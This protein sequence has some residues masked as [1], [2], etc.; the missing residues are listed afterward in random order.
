MLTLKTDAREISRVGESTAKRLKK[1]GIENA[2]DLLFYFPF[3]YD[4][5]TRLTPIDKLLAGVSANVVGQIELIQN[6]RSWKRR[7]NIT[8]ALITDGTETL[9]VIWFN[10]PFIARNLKVGDKISLAGKVEDDYGSFVMKSPVYEKIQIPLTPFVKGGKYNPPTPPYQGG[11]NAIH[12]QGLVPNYHLT[13]NLTHKQVRFLIKQIITL[14]DGVDDWLPGEIKKDIK[15]INLAEAIRKIHFPKNNSDIKKARERLAF[16]ELFLIQ[17][18]SQLVRRSLDLSRAPAIKFQETETKKFVDSLPFKLTDAQRKAAWEILQDLAK[19]KPMTRLLEG[20]VGSGKTIVVIIAMLNVALS[21]K[22]AVLM[23]PTEILA[24][25]HYDTVCRLLAG[26]DV[27]VGLVTRSQKKMNNVLGIL[28]N[29]EEIKKDEQSALNTKY[30]I[31]NTNII[32]GTHALIQED[33][34]PVKSGEAGAQPFNRVEFKNLA[35]AVIDEQHRFGVEQRKKL[36]EKSG[37]EL[38]P[39]LLSMTATP[40]PRSLAL[41]LYGDLDL[42]VLNQMPKDRK[43]IITSV[44][45]ES[46]R[47]KA[48]EFIRAQIKEGRQV[49][50]ICPLIDLSDKLGVKSVEEEYRKLDKIVFP[51]L[52]MGKL[53]GKMKALEK[54]KIM[55]EFLA[56]KIKILV[57]T[58][59][60]E[61][62]VDVP[63]ASVMMIEG[64]D[65]FGLA[66]LHQ[67]RG[68]VGRSVHQSYCFLF[69][70]NDNEQTLNRLEALVKYSNG[71]ELAKIDLKFR[72]P[73]EV[74][75]VEQKGFPELKM[76]SLFDYALMKQARDQA[77]KLINEDASL[78]NWPALKERLGE[79]EKSVHLE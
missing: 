41:A 67:F 56:G 31:Q 70:D 71:F 68:R 12:T 74:Y 5:F 47:A 15:L 44:V 59:V 48:Y 51:E 34:H 8:E 17:L 6:K 2:R 3:R 45:P 32:I 27:K 55:S 9:K 53:H 19:D 69:T 24:K 35:L 23:V 16:D 22:Q 60:V 38:A 62:G 10:Q 50:V 61:V 33:I 26:F 28:Y 7:M 11:S 73:G 66:Q 36:L 54:E 58:S 21:G 72:G 52:T 20:D 77:L 1:L 14:A 18:Q 79:W 76:A 37:S 42:S 40:I 64:A 49:F 29:G 57:A 78:K 46:K 43:K 39:H 75:G 30:I 63:N 4:D 25:Q 13:A 65:R